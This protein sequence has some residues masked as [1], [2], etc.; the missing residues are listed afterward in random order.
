MLR[1][2]DSFYKQPLVFDKSYSKLMKYMKGSQLS[3][4]YRYYLMGNIQLG[5]QKCIDSYTDC[6]C[7]YKMCS[8]KHSLGKSCI[9]KRRRFSGN[10]KIVKLKSSSSN[11]RHC[12]NSNQKSSLDIVGIVHLCKRYSYL[13]N[14]CMKTQIHQILRSFYLGM[15]QDNIHHIMSKESGKK[16][17]ILQRC[18]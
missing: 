12:I 8:S 6:K 1:W 13:N 10:Q 18:S 14:L 11:R 9:G 16:Y 4:Y 5:S 7:Y 15:F 3:K 17:R 2:L